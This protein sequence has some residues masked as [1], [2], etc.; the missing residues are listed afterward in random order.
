MLYSYGYIKR[1]NGTGG[2]GDRFLWAFNTS[3]NRSELAEVDL[4]DEYSM[5]ANGQDVSIPRNG[6]SFYTG[7]SVPNSSIPATMLVL[8]ADNTGSTPPKFS[9]LH[10][11]TLGLP[12]PNITGGAMVYIPLG[13]NGTLISFGG[14]MIFVLYMLAS[15]HTDEY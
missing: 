12:P 7:G 15:S 9:Y 6:Q 10:K 5:V 13:H 4:E 11:G 1:P 2:I 3:S 14:V 8:N